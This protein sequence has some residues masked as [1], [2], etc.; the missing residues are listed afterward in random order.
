MGLRI[1]KPVGWRIY[2]SL[3][4]MMVLIDRLLIHCMLLR[5]AQIYTL[6]THLQPL[7]ENPQ[8]FWLP[9]TC[10]LPLGRLPATTFET[11]TACPSLLWTQGRLHRCP[12]DRSYRQPQ[13]SVRCPWENDRSFGFGDCWGSGTTVLLRG[14]LGVWTTWRRLLGGCIPGS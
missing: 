2:H 9:R 3:Y 13:R 14:A 8:C 10:T 4:A 1:C 12:I 11:G 5:I 7:F 6:T